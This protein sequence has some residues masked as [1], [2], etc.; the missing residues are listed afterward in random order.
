M[1]ELALTL[2][3]DVPCGDFAW[4]RHV[5]L[6]DAAYVGADI[7]PTARSTAVRANARDV[8]IE[9]LS[10]NDEPASV[11]DTQSVPLFFRSVSISARVLRGLSWLFFFQKPQVVSSNAE[12]FSSE[13]RQFA[14]LD[15]ADDATAPTALR[16]AL[17]ASIPRDVS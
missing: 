13:T 4:M 16:S 7:V 10:P 11:S 14:T 5:D 6:G 9:E 8:M 12:S 3:L 1:R 17:D 2:V 15:L